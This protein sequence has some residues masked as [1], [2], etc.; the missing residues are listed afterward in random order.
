[1][2]VFSGHFLSS[3]PRV[4]FSH[5]SFLK[6]TSIQNMLLLRILSSYQKWPANHFAMSP[7]VLSNAGFAYR[8]HGLQVACPT[9]GL[10][11]EAKQSNAPLNP[12]DEH[13][14]RSPQCPLI[15]ESSQREV[16]S[17]YSSVNTPLDNPLSVANTTVDV[18]LSAVSG[19]SAATADSGDVSVR[20]HANDKDLC[21]TSRAATVRTNELCADELRAGS[22]ESPV[23]R[24]NPDFRRLRLERRRLETFHDWP[25]TANVEPTELAADGWFYTGSKDRVCCAFCRGKLHKWTKS[26]RPASE[27]R[28]HFEDCPFVRGHDVGNVPLTEETNTASAAQPRGEHRCADLTVS[29]DEEAASNS[30][31][32]RYGNDVLPEPNGCEHVALDAATIAISTTLQTKQ[33]PTETAVVT[34]KSS[35]SSMPEGLYVTVP[36]GSGQIWINR[37]KSNRIETNAICQCEIRLKSSLSCASLRDILHMICCH[38]RW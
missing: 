6:I 25:K 13:R 12:R 3:Y 8:G 16:S 21:D 26:D 11:I 5:D 30:L 27:H 24:K 9:C 22:M 7:S 10:E 14:R 19:D 20:K 29:G 34:T 33:H 18:S 38:L 36:R 32:T 31:G 35:D 28:R 15:L 1:M 23:D 2:Y 37:L 17:P 4:H